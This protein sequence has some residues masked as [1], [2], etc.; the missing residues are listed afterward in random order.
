MESKIKIHS[1][2][3]ILSVF[4][5]AALIAVAEM[6]NIFENVLSQ[7]LEDSQEGSSEAIDRAPQH[8]SSKDI[9][10][11]EDEP[12]SNPE[13]SSQ[14]GQEDVLED[15]D[16]TSQ[17]SSSKDIDRS[18]DE[19][20]SNPERSSQQGQEDVLEESNGIR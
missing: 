12:R 17:H 16:E 2:V 18:E 13:R 20:R 9:D 10:R 5:S 1:I 8:S 6:P 11:S 7:Q 4:V 3:I 15:L 14:Q 19:P